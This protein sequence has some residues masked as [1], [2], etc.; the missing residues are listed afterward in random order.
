MARCAYA[1]LRGFERVLLI[2]LGGGGGFRGN[3]FNRTQKITFGILNDLVSVFQTI[4]SRSAGCIV[5][6]VYVLST[7]FFDKRSYTLKTA[8]QV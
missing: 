2:G 8:R 4:N 3:F 1:N 5:V 6:C 7:A